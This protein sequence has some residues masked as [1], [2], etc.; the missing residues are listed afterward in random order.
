MTEEYLAD[1]SI[2]L[3]G[4]TQI[5]WKPVIL[6]DIYLFK[7]RHENLYFIY[8][9]KMFIYTMRMYSIYLLVFI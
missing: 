8:L 2:W 6:I 9:M 7:Q 1:K 5:S 4:H 3:L